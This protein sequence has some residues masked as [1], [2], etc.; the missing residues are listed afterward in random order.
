MKKEAVPKAT[1][2]PHTL[3]LSPGVAFF[4]WREAPGELGAGVL[5]GSSRLFAS[6]TEASA[7]FRGTEGFLP[8]ANERET[9]ADPS[10]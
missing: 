8:R 9:I 7:V 2:M 10:G 6:Q 1:L 5:Q 4:N 3:R